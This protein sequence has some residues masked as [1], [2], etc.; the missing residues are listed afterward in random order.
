MGGLDGAAILAHALTLAPSVAYFVPK[1]TDLGQL[2]SLAR[3]HGLP[4]E[5]E[6]CS[7]NGHE[8]T[9]ARGRELKHARPHAEIV[10]C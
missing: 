3:D 6:R 5:I 10:C 2:A 7:L 1:N 8:S 9:L 4:L